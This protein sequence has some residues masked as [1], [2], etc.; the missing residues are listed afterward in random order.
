MPLYFGN[1]IIPPA[2]VEYVCLLDQIHR[3]FRPSYA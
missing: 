2:Q 3:Y 1:M